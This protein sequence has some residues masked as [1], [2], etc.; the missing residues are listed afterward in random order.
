[1]ETNDFRI[2]YYIDDNFIDGPVNYPRYYNSNLRQLFQLF[3]T[4]ELY[5]FFDF[6]KKIYL[7]EEFNERNINEEYYSYEKF[8]RCKEIIDYFIPSQKVLE[9]CVFC[10]EYQLT[11]TE[12][13]IID[14]INYYFHKRYNLIDVLYDIKQKTLEMNINEI[15]DTVNNIVKTYNIHLDKEESFKN[16]LY[17]L[18]ESGYHNGIIDILK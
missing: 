3:H 5:K 17:N 12:D 16:D 8:L 9:D 1:M 7:Y 11:G 6:I 14:K 18:Y 15:S 2:Q 13:E 4:D 10:N